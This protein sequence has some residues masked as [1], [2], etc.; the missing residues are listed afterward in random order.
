M[1]PGGALEFTLEENVGPVSVRG[2]HHGGRLTFWMTHPALTYGR[3]VERAEVAAAIG[4]EEAHFVPDVQCQ[5][6]STGNPLLFAAL[7]EPAAVDQ[8]VSDAA[9]LATVLDGDAFGVFLFAPA[10]RNRLYSRMFS[11]AIPEDPAT[12]SGSGPLG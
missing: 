4:V 6:V 9:R 8:A 12:G 10:G 11:I 2:V 3:T 5:V 7:R 1:V